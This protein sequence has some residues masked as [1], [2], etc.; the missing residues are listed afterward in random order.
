MLSAQASSADTALAFTVLAGIVVGGTSILGGVGAVWRTVVG[1]LFIALIGNGYILLGLDPLY[2]QITMGADPP[3]RRRPG[4]M[5]DAIGL[6][7]QRRAT[8]AKGSPDPDWIA[9]RI[10]PRIRARRIELGISL[11]EFARRIDVS[12][13]FVSPRGDGT[14]LALGRDAASDDQRAAHLGERAPRRPR[15]NDS[16]S[17]TDSSCLTPVYSRCSR[18]R[19]RW[20]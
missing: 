14:L 15:V 20:R 9:E 5:D 1:V 18:R 6:A 12:P 11:R 8:P 10:G 13:S 7:M 17:G 19:R 4:R 2:E 3:R 16:G